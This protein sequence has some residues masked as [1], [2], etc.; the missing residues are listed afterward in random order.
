MWRNHPSLTE[1]QNGA[2]NE[3]ENWHSRRMALID[4]LRCHLASVDD[5]GDFKT[6]ALGITVNSRFNQ[7]DSNRYADAFAATV[8]VSN[9][10]LPKADEE[11]TS[12]RKRKRCD[13]SEEDDDGEQ[14]PRAEEV[15]RDALQ[16]AL[17]VVPLGVSEDVHRNEPQTPAALRHSVWTERLALLLCTELVAARCT[18]SLPCLIHCFRCE[19][20]FSPLA[21]KQRAN[22]PAI[23]LCNELATGGNLQQWAVAKQRRRAREWHACVFHILAASTRCKSTAH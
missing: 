2:Q 23:V 15:P 22:Q 12:P 4:R 16:M 20:P 3:I 13:S 11:A 1:P 14:K 18:P 5:H 8:L 19:Q 17:K 7:A 9:S 10:S 21:L 6:A